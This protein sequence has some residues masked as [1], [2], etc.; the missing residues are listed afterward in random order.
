MH[1]FK[2][3]KKSECR[4]TERNI[5][6]VFRSDAK[7]PENKFVI[8]A[9]GRSGTTFL[10]DLLNNHSKIHCDGEILKFKAESPYEYVNGRAKLST[11][12]NYGFKIKSWH[13]EN[14]HDFISSLHEDGWKII[15]LVRKNIFRKA[16]S[17]QLA[18]VNGY[19][20]YETPDLDKIELDVDQL[21]LAMD[22]LKEIMEQD[23][24]VMSK[25]PHIRLGYESDLLD[26]YQS[27]MNSVF[28]FLGLEPEIVGSDFKKITPD[29]WEDF[30]SNSEQVRHALC[31]NGY[32]E[33]L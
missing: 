1:R 15:H 9:L 24:E 26:D 30:V 20:F 27:S 31:E 21:L 23:K 16:I 5:Y 25:F 19:H 18:K 11:L 8:F 12:P 2:I 10:C 6:D 17:Y 3:E 28:K 13:V 29:N 32:E 22:R 33:F 7:L 14:S 4:E